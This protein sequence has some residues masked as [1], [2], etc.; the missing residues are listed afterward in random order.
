MLLEIRMV[1]RSVS[2][3]GKVPSAIDAFQSKL[4]ACLQAVQAAIT[5]GASQ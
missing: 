4:I 1:M 2:G 3:C 5:I